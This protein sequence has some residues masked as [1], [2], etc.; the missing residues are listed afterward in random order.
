MVTTGF[1]ANNSPMVS[2]LYKETPVH[3]TD[4]GSGNTIVF[5]HGF[6]ESSEI[7]KDF[8]ASLSEKF[9]IICI[10]LPGHGKS[11]LLPGKNY[12][13]NAAGAV[14]EVLQHCDI[15]ECVL[16]GHSMGGYVALAFAENFPGMLRGLILFHS[17]ALADSNEKK[18]DRDR[19]IEAVRRDHPGY[20]S[21]LIPKLFAPQN[22]E[23]MKEE[24]SVVKKLA[25][26]T[27]KQGILS[28]IEG[29]RDRKERTGVLRRTEAP[30]LFLQGRHDALIPVEKILPQAGLP[31]CAL[32][33]VLEHSGHMGFIEEKEESLFTVL[34]FTEFCFSPGKHVS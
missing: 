19:A 17:S 1:S 11:G 7:W 6:L 18:K 25:S 29:M 28:A 32:A 31:A 33:I 24:I 15:K 34:K 2:V 5:L 4:E 21:S 12:M 26:G 20:V 16:A 9:R 3:Y 10:D 22:S 27:K 30:V 14:M 8:S 23:S 13:E